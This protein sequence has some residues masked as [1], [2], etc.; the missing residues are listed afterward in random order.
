M[1]MVA[2]GH[3]EECWEWTGSSDRYGRFR[4]DDGSQIGAHRYSYRT[5]KGPLIRGMEIMHICDNTL[6]VN[7]MHL[8]QGTHQ[9]NVDDMI[10]KGRENFFG[11]RG[12]RTEVQE[13]Y[14]RMREDRLDGKLLKEIAEKYGV[15]ISLVSRVCKDIDIGPQNR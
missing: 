9:E 12:S 7:P 4:D 13:R 10:V 6:C 11:S 3:P 2:I 5:W 14:E 15:H 8:T 1:R